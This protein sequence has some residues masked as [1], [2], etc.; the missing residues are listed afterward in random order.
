MIDVARA[1]QASGLLRFVAFAI[2]IAGFIDPAI[3]VSGFSRARVAAVVQQPASPAAGS[4]RDRLI[5]DLSTSYDIVSNVTSDTAAAVVIGERYPDEPMPDSLLVA[6]VTTADVTTPGVRIIRVDAPH[7]VPAATVIRLDVELGGFRIAGRTTDVTVGIAGLE[8]GRA[9][10]RWTADEEQWRASI[11]AVPVGEPPFVLRV[12]AKTGQVRLKPDTTETVVDA[13]PAGKTPVTPVRLKPD[14]TETVVDATPAGETPVVSGF[15]RTVAD[16]VVDVRRAPFRVQFYDPRPSWATTF[17]RRALEA[18]VRFQVATLSFISRGIS[19]Q[20]GGDVPLGDPRID[21]FDVVIVGGLD[22]LSVADA[23]SLDRYMRERGGAVVLVPDQ[24]IDAGPARDLIAGPDIVERLLEQPAKLAVTPP[25]ASLQASELL[26][27]RALT[28]GSDVIARVPGSD[29]SPVIVSTPRGEG[30][31][32]LSGAMDAWRFRA[33]DEGAFDRFWQSTIAGLALAAPPPIAISVVPPLLRPGERGEVVVRLRSQIV[34]SISA[35]LDGDQP[36]RLRPEPEAGVYRG[37]FTAKSAPGRSTIEVRAAAAEPLL[38]SR[39]LLV[40]GDVQRVRLDA[41]PSLSMLASS[42]R[43]I[44]VT[45]GRVADLERFLR[46]SVISPATTLVR[47]PMR[48]TWWI[49]PFG[50]CLSA[51]WWMRRR[52]GLR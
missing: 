35:S 10:H 41:M 33:A 42:H 22:R 17:L 23:R 18:D 19:A 34:T 25:A 48:S 6:T 9:S 15:S 30:R 51:E 16:V 28:P 40:Q 49:L 38:A 47:H 45:P 39:T 7:E 27:L 13:T 24:R 26:V 52:R 1:L 2:A 37:S 43:G 20:T 44:D 11:D 12:E 46:S 8:V 31:L 3:S 29:G 4:V 14:T 21:R 5:R 36:I 32:L 50:V